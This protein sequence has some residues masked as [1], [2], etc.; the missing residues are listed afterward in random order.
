MN[1]EEEDAKP[2][3]LPPRKSS[4]FNQPE[5]T[6]PSLIWVPPSFAN[7]SQESHSGTATGIFRKRKTSFKAAIHSD[8][9][10]EATSTPSESKTSPDTPILPSHIQPRTN[11]SGLLL[12]IFGL[13]GLLVAGLTGWV[14]YH[15]GFSAGR[16][17]FDQLRAE[18]PSPIPPE[19]LVSIESALADYSQGNATEATDKLET[20]Y[21][22][23]QTIP[24]TCYLLALMAIQSGDLKLAK[25]KVDESI[26]KGEKVSD[27]LALKAAIEME[28]ANRLGAKGMS[29]PKVAAE[30]LLRSAMA[31]DISNPRPYIELASLLRFQGRNDE[32]RELF[33]GASRR[34]NP[35]EGHTLVDTSLVFLDLRETPDSKLPAT[36]NPDK[37]IPS[38]F[39]AAYVAMRK[40]D[41]STAKVLLTKARERL[42]PA[43]YEY[44]VNDPAL[45]TF[46]K[47]P[48]LS[49]L[50]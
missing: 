16:L 45:K 48:Q 18:L 31:A 23:N 40:N 2:K 33:K 20:V 47:N 43:L 13:F 6:S 39:A 17:Y 21:R 42:S 12:L 38:L 41:F 28:S 44:L 32:A 11:S 35:V 24:S 30:S 7:K 27:S 34:L 9:V 3:L 4:V 29:D 1:P 22:K 8:Q 26:L 46:S 49:G 10:P 19:F 14:A 36:L 15:Q 37:D 25:Q 5:S 50:F